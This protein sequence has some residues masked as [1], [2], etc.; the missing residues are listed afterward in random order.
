LFFPHQFSSVFPYGCPSKG[1]AVGRQPPTHTPPS[2]PFC[3]ERTPPPMST[4]EFFSK[5][6]AFFS[7]VFPCLQLP[8]GFFFLLNCNAPF[9]L[10]FSPPPPPFLC[11]LSYSPLPFRW[12]APN[13]LRANCRRFI[14]DFLQGFL[15]PFP[16]AKTFVCDS[17]LFFFPKQP[18][19][20]WPCRPAVLD[21]SALF[22]FSP[23]F[24]TTAGP[25][26]TSSF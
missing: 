21:Y 6:V 16:L 17:S 13:Y 12:T 25:R 15:L 22:C 18:P 4:S 1:F 8:Y 7:D 3:S 19:L 20:A 5:T 10:F 23:P 2:A 26:H 14:P 9:S 11:F 24:L